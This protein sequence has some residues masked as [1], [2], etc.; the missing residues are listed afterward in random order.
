MRVV[1]IGISQIT[2]MAAGLL[3]DHGH[4]VVIVERDKEKIDNFSDKLD[5]GF[6]HGDGSTPLRF[7]RNSILTRRIISSALRAVIR[8]ILLQH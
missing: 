5:C 1:M 4:E 2:V 3:L 8:P 7:Y 6:I